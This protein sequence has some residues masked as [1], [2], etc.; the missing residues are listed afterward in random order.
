MGIRLRFS[1]SKNVPGPGY[2]DG[3]SLKTLK[4]EPKYGFGQESR[5]QKPSKV[6]AVP[7]AGTYNPNFKAVMLHEATWTVP[8]SKRFTVK[9]GTEDL[10]SAFTYTIK[11]RVGNEGPQFIIGKQLRDEKIREISPGPIY[12]PQFEVTKKKM[13]MFS[14]RQKNLKFLTGLSSP[15]LGPGHYESQKIFKKPPLTVFGKQK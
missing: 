13:P 11:P 2:Y 9:K 1:S 6:N 5:E 12:S 10:P 8:N 3:D 15:H 14:M 7:E 4:A